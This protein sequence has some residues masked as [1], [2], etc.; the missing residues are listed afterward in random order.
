MVS[1]DPEIYNKLSAKE[2]NKRT[3][4]S[5]IKSGAFDSIPGTRKQLMMIYLQ[6]L[7][8]VTKEKKDNLSGQ[9]SFFDFMG[10]EQKAK[11]QDA[12]PDIGEYTNEEILS[13]EKEV[14]GIYISGH[15]LESYQELLEKNITVTSVDF[16][17]D[18]E[19]NIPNVEDGNYETIGGI[20]S[21]VTRKTTKT[22]AL[23]A[24]I[25]IEDIIGNVE[26][27]IFQ[28]NMKYHSIIVGS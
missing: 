17:L 1:L 22:N 28:G 16:M 2:V 6:I 19:T 15:P 21:S 11:Y 20:I 7:E 26:V 10:E 5:F 13:F 24:F 8:D 4:E 25:T 18:D 12:Y 9:M 27:I 23:M 14:L 3:I